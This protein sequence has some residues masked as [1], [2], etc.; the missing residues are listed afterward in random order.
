MLNIL[1]WRWSLLDINWLFNHSIDISWHLNLHN[2][3]N[4]HNLIEI[5]LFLHN[6]FDNLLFWDL[7]LLDL[8]FVPVNDL[9]FL[10]LSFWE[11]DV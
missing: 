8:Y 10:L 11:G 6:F 7:N 5:N 9:D 4:F 2:L 1:L 3:F